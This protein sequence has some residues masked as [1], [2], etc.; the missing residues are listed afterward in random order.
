MKL[1]TKLGIAVV[2][3]VLLV[4]IGYMI[5]FSSGTSW[6]TS[7]TAPK[8]ESKTY[9]LETE[10]FNMRVYTFGHPTN[11]MKECIAAASSDGAGVTCF[12]K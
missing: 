1:I 7:L 2:I 4:I 10:G 11:K 9:Q 8:I 6:F 3:V 5:K 12:D